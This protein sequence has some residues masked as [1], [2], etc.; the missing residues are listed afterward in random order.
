[1][2]GFPSCCHQGL[3]KCPLPLLPSWGDPDSWIGPA[4]QQEWS[5]V[6]E[7]HPSCL[8]L[9][10][11][12][13]SCKQFHCSI[14][15]LAIP[16]SYKRDWL[17]QLSLVLVGRKICASI[18]YTANTVLNYVFI[19]VYLLPRSFA[20]A[21]VAT[22]IIQQQTFNIMECT[23]VIMV[24]SCAWDSDIDKLSSLRIYSI[25]YFLPGWQQRLPWFLPVYVSIPD[26]FV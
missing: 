16:I 6:E 12:P 7:G 24:T 11:L 26:M 9:I 2:P 20:T 3:K 23:R 8:W 19:Y 25:C 13:V 22:K 14:G 10:V 18:A 1:M 4:P 21:R 5:P 15:P 17:R